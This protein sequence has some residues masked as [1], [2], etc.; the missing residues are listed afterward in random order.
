MWHAF[1]LKHSGR[2]LKYLTKLYDEKPQ[3]EILD[4]QQLIAKDREQNWAHIAQNIERLSITANPQGF[5][6]F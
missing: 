4:E 1:I 6:V 2:Q 3:R 5:R